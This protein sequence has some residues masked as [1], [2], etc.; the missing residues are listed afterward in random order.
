MCMH[1]DMIIYIDVHGIHV[2]CPIL[3]FHFSAKIGNNMPQ[4]RASPPEEEPGSMMK[5]PRSFS[6]CSS[7]PDCCNARGWWSTWSTWSIGATGLSPWSRFGFNCLQGPFRPSW[8]SVSSNFTTRFSAPI[9]SSRS[10]QLQKL[11]S[12]ALL[13]AWSFPWRR[14]RSSGQCLAPAVSVWHCKLFGPSSSTTS[15]GAMRWEGCASCRCR[16]APCKHNWMEIQRTLDKNHSD[17]FFVWGRSQCQDMITMFWQSNKV[18]RNFWFRLLFPAAKPGLQAVHE[19]CSR[20]VA[21]CHLPVL[22]PEDNGQTSVMPRR[23]SGNNWF[24]HPSVSE[25]TRVS[26]CIYHSTL[27]SSTWVPP[28]YI[29]LTGSLCGCHVVRHAPGGLL[30]LWWEHWNQQARVLSRKWETNQLWLHP[31]TWQFWFVLGQ[32]WWLFWWIL[33]PTIFGYAQRFN[34]KSHTEH[35]GLALWKQGHLLQPSCG[36]LWGSLR[37]QFWDMLWMPLVHK[38]RQWIIN[39]TSSVLESSSKQRDFLWG[40]S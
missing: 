2:V 31:G 14:I 13:G 8:P 32:M 24:C 17:L 27:N 36:E 16:H 3:W 1:V 29:G 33:G 39:V 9:F 22:R 4:S 20:W 12:A 28:T 19:P 25:C 18:W 7:S 23:Q 26:E 15:L 10:A 21:R 6:L 30:V 5:F 40:I 34:E 35:V 37:K 38:C 11:L